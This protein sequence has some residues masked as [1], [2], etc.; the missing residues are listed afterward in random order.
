MVPAVS[1][2]HERHDAALAEIDTRL[3]RGESLVTAGPALL[4]TYSVFTRLPPPHRLAPGD[5]WALLDS[6]FVRGEMAVLESQ[7][8]RQLL[9]QLARTGIAGGQAY[10]ATIA[11]CARKAGVETLLTFNRRHFDGFAG[12]D[13]AIVVPGEG[14]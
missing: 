13:L 9:V 8:Y 11:A 1:S 7:G 4:E 2:W 6:N 10:D 14:V 12:P 5:A 3:D